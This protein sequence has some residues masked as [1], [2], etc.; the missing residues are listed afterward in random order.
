[1][2]AL[3][4][5]CATPYQSA[6]PNWFSLGVDGGF[7]VSGLRG[8]VFRVRFVG[9]VNTTSETTQTYA[10]Y[11][12]AV[13]AEEQGFAGFEIVSAIEGLESDIPS[14]TAQIR[15]LRPPFTPSPPKVFDATRLKA[16]L[17]PYVMGMKCDKDN[18]C[19]HDHHYLRPSGS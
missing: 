13:L 3:A 7:M 2:A 1:M 15:L 6:A 16:A 17:E 10:L 18:V 8:G 19:P 11:R 4:G 14:Y 9:N 12:S 5:G